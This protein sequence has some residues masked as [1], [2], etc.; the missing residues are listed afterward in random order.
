MKI[1]VYQNHI[2]LSEYVALE[3]DLIGGSEIFIGRSD[4]CHIVL[5]SHQ[6]SRHHAI[7]YF[8]QGQLK[9]RSNSAFG[10]VRINGMEIDQTIISGSTKIEILDYEIRLDDIQFTS[11][12][13]EEDTTADDITQ[14]MP[15]PNQEMS[16]PQENSSDQGDL[17]D[18]DYSLADELVNEE[19]VI[20]T[21]L[22]ED[23]PLPEPDENMD[24]DDLSE[25]LADLENDQEVTEE[26]NPEDD[27]S[28]DSDLDNEQ[29]DEIPSEDFGGSFNEFAADEDEFAGAGL[30]DEGGFADDDS[31]TQVFSS[32]AKYKLKIFGEFAPFDSFV[33]DDP[34]TKIGRDANECQI[35]LDDPEVSKV[36][37]FIRKTIVDCVLEDNDSSNGIIFNGERVNKAELTNGDEFII[38]ETTFTVSISSDILESEKGRLMPVEDNQEVVI[39]EELAPQMSFGDEGASEI[40]FSNE[41]T[42]GKQSL[43]AQIKNDPKKKRIAMIVGVLLLIL[44]LMDTETPEKKPEKKQ[45]AKPKQETKSKISPEKLE[46][47]E[48]NYQ[49]ASTKFRE[50]QYYEA[51][52]Y[53]NLVKREDPN[54]K[55]TATLDKSIQDSLDAIKRN[56][57]EERRQRERAEKLKKISDLLVKAKDAVDKRQVEV[58]RQYIASITEL[59]PDNID[60]PPLKVELDAYVEE[61]ERKKQEEA[62]AKARRNAMEE[63]LKPGELAYLK[64][65]YFKA[66]NELNKFLTIKD[67]DKDLIEKATRMLKDSNQ[68]ILQKVEPLLSRARSFKEGQDLKQ[69]Y[70]TYTAVLKYQPNNEEARTEREKI[71]EMLYKRSR[72]IFRE[73]LIKEDLSDF[74]NAKEKFEEVKQISPINSEYYIKA[75]EKLKNYL[76]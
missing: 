39:E 73:A 56:E 43:L 61:V 64:Q 30:E 65:D 34:I 72:K 5:D 68:K 63:K 66:V 48:Q 36:H 60:V 21:P 27:D 32:F 7:I 16:E 52:E 54:Y 57:E 40:D 55:A 74:A 31:K 26:L 58:A 35:V 20:E 33:I 42:V 6:I 22:E 38:G 46:I 49:L 47:L 28:L 15:A 44:F 50:G 59:D 24:L 13:E 3:E 23:E 62:L 12:Q 41:T 51:K 4:D 18:L 76:E 29:T 9:I 25:D 8:D 45:V 71:F 2:L 75:Q 17:A 67:M 1:S 37:A 10:N 70:E 69:A 11:E 53:I 14:M 19:T